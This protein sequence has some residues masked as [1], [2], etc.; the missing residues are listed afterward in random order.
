MTFA[1]RSGFFE[2]IENPQIDADQSWSIHYDD[3][4]ATL[5][6]G[7][8]TG[9]PVDGVFDVPGEL[10]LDGAFV[11]NDALIKLGTGDLIIDTADVTGVGFGAM[12][13]VVDGTVRLEGGGVLVLSDLQFGDIGLATGEASLV[14][15]MGFYAAVVPEP[16]IV[17]VFA[18]AAPLA[19]V[20]RARRRRKIA[21]H[22][23]SSSRRET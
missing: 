6:A 11:W 7:R 12:L 17:A 13:A 10:L 22:P 19:V 18:I 15:T 21:D 9:A 20:R 4:S 14:G 2:S 8:L 3:D 1:S 5:L 23:S 16:G